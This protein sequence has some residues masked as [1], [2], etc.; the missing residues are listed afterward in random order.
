MNFATLY[1]IDK[2]CLY[3]EFTSAHIVIADMQL[4]EST[5]QPQ[6]ILMTRATIP[7]SR[8]E[9]ALSH[10]CLSP[11]PSHSLCIFR[12]TLFC[13]GTAI[14]T[15][16][17]PILGQVHLL[18]LKNRKTALRHDANLGSALSQ[19]ETHIL[20]KRAVAKAGGYSG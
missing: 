1:Q 9:T 17:P 16:C 20:R 6:A 14:P 2:L 11:P 5:S 13:S 3:L 15:K 12:T 18:Q 4:L 7:S 8:V 19:S 10:A